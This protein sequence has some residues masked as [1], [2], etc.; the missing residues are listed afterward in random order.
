MNKPKI[1][2]L[3]GSSRFIDIMA[4]CGWLIERDENAI[5]VGVA[6]IA[7]LVSQYSEASSC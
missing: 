7:N 6:F 3:S 5:V 4:V 2:C 1:V